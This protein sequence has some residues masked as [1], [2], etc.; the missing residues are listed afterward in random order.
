MRYVLERLTMPIRR[1]G[2]ASRLTT[3]GLL[4]AIVFAAL[5]AASVEASSVN[6]AH[7]AAVSAE[8][9]L[10]RAQKNLAAIEARIKALPPQTSAAVAQLA[11]ARNDLRST[12][13]RAYMAGDRS[14]GL[15]LLLGGRNLFESSA[16][17]NMTR[18]SARRNAAIVRRYRRLASASNRTRRQLAAQLQ[19]AQRQVADATD[20]AF[21]ARAEERD[22]VLTAEHRSAAATAAA[23]RA[24]TK[25]STNANPNAALVSTGSTRRT[26]VTTTTTIAARAA[27]RAQPSITARPTTTTTTTTTTPPTT[28]TAPRTTTTVPVAPPTTAP[29]GGPSEAQWARLRKCESGG[30]YAAVNPS[31]KYRGAYQFDYRTWN[32]LGTPGDPAAAAPAEQDRR[33]KLLYSYRGWKPWPQCG[34]FLW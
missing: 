4:S 20:A 25:S 13:V 9:N 28:T 32:A 11:A 29:P 17:V 7:T 34:R 18:N 19:R 16:R 14:E 10:A 1:H 8:A 22:A 3:L 30:N 26:S 23:R 27:A 6:D 21:A 2:V 12:T 33:A 24:A 31:G 15:T 5:P